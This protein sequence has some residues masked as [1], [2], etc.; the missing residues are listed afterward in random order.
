[1]SAIGRDTAEYGM[2]R[3]F[4]MRDDEDII[5]DEYSDDSNH[6]ERLSEKKSK[7]TLSIKLILL[8]TISAFGYST[9]GTTFA[10]D[11]Q[12]GSGRVEFGQG[13]L[14]STACDSQVIVTPFATFAN[15]SGVAAKYKLTDI[16]LSDI[17]A[18]CYGRDFII[19][20]YDSAT[21][22]PLNL[23]QTGGTT[24]YNSLR[25][26]NNNGTF[27]LSDSGL[28]QAEIIAVTSGFKVTLFNSASPA[29]VALAEATNVFRI[30]VE[31]VAHDSTLSQS[32]VPS[33]S[34]F[35]TGGAGATSID[36]AS[37]SAFSLGTGAFTLELWAKLPSTEGN[38]TFYDAGGDVNSAGSF[39]FWIESNLLLIRRNGLVGDI[40]LPM[41]NAWR[42]GNYH[43]FAAVRGNG[44]YRIFVDG[45]LKKEAADSGHTISRTEPRIGR[46][47]AYQTYDLD[48]DLR[49]LRLVKGTALYS[50]N[51]TPP[52][53][54]L[55]KVSGTLLLL[56]AQDAN[57][58]FLD[59]S[60]N[61]F[62]PMNSANLPTYR[63]P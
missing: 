25:I 15:A 1:M 61:N 4:V 59:S 62:T 48:G 58:P 46:L 11:V 57:N 49:N 53:T 6:G 21:A 42:D 9:L 18:D 39:A 40:T 13:V 36:Y 26:Y 22:T 47:S 34:L 54:P 56:L 3:G 50:S 44:K 20:A 41:E 2:K 63:A 33:G 14:T 23:Y 5:S 29:A 10:T 45:V 37:N 55:T 17:S 16:Q 60:D 12:L 27:T 28:T 31:S 38:E 7:K 19:K 35:F 24:N 52:T 51:F 43:H 30:T 32:S 8:A